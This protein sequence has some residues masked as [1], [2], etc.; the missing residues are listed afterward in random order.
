MVET[1]GWQQIIKPKLES[2]MNN[3]WLDPRKT[4]DEKDFFH[5]YIVAWANAN[6]IDEILKMIEGYVK[7]VE[8]LRAKEKQD[9]PYRIGQ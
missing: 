7:T 3:S 1:E 4:S 2:K 5:Q 9:A 8:N 6:A